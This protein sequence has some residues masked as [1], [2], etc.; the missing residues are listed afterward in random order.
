M[1]YSDEVK[2]G[3]LSINFEDLNS[4]LHHLMKGAT[5]KA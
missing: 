1:R 3:M 4:K 5:S 2:K